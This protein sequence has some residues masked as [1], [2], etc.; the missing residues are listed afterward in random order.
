MLDAHYTYRQIVDIL[1]VS[2]KT[3]AKVAHGNIENLCQSS[4][5]S[6]WDSYSDE[7]LD[8]IRVGK[9]GKQI[10]NELVCRYKVIGKLTSFY[11]YIAQLAD[12]AGIQLERYHHRSTPLPDGNI[13]QNDFD[14]IKRNGV[15]QYLW[16]GLELNQQHLDYLCEKYP[17]LQ[18]LRKRILEFRE[19]FRQ[20]NPNLLLLFIDNCIS[21]NCEK[22]SRFASGLQQD[23]EAVFNAVVSDLS[24]AFVEGTNNKIKMVK[25]VMYG[26]CKLPLL[27]A[28][29]IGRQLEDVI[30]ST[31]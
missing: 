21:G 6:I 4:C 10:Y 26:R 30:P 31:A 18:I 20:K 1:Q 2:R 24:N 13:P 8:G 9:T 12:N 14:F 27:K 29:L 3:I 22:L 15:L 19:I 7:M 28:K 17:I 16:N 23:L 11:S 25:R 5:H